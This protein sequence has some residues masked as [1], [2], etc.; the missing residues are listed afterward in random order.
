MEERHKPL[1]ITGQIQEGKKLHNVQSS[2]QLILVQYNT[3]GSETFV[4]S[5]RFKNKCLCAMKPASS[6]HDKRIRVLEWQHSGQRYLFRQQNNMSSKRWTDFW[7]EKKQTRQ[8]NTRHPKPGDAIQGSLVLFLSKTQKR[9]LIC[10]TEA[11]PPTDGV[12]VFNSAL[13]RSD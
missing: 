12:P 11:K 7:K 3:K 4:C 2:L 13:P 10:T 5:A 9:F 8:A 1:G 6:V